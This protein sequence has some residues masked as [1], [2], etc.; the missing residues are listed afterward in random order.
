MSMTSQHDRHSVH[1]RRVAA[2]DF[3]NP[4]RLPVDAL[5]TAIATWVGAIAE[6]AR[7]P[8]DL[9]AISA[10][11]TL[12]GAAIGGPRLDLGNREEE[13]G[14]YL[15][16]VLPSGERK[17]TVL[18]PAMAPL[19]EIEQEARER[20]APLIR[21]RRIRKDV[22]ESSQRKLTRVA[23]E[24]PDAETREDAQRRLAR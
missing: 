20:A 14:L 10:L 22:L 7:A 11:G 5:P 1:A 18:R 24:S 13:L 15:L 4:V 16:A 3:E 21:E 9:P 12:A 2:A 6:Q 8:A 19:L 17:S 23:G